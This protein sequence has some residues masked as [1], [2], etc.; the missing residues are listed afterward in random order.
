MLIPTTICDAVRVIIKE[1][2]YA[3]VNYQYTFF[4]HIAYIQGS[5]HKNVNFNAQLRDVSVLMIITRQILQ[6]KI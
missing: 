6:A 2:C 5:L 3:Y 4:L 1:F